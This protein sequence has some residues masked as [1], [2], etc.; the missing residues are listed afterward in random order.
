MKSLTD[1]DPV[2]S[3]SLISLIRLK[4]VTFFANLINPTWDQWNVAWWSTMEVNI[5]I[6]CTCLPTM[7]LI[8]KRIFPK[9]LA[10][11]ERTTL[12]SWT[13][14][15]SVSKEDTKESGFAMEMSTTT[16]VAEAPS[17][18]RRLD[19][20]GGLKEEPTTLTRIEG[21]VHPKEMPSAFQRFEGDT[22]FSSKAG[23]KSPSKAFEGSTLLKRLPSYRR[24][25]DRGARSV[26]APNPPFAGLEA[27]AI[28][29]EQ[30]VSVSVTKKYHEEYDDNKWI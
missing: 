4:S 14:V 6:I 30:R 2:S 1:C 3:V 22:S 10:T 19:D 15:A 28:V 13:A 29:M 7:R 11:D 23:L 26:D 20:R 18:Y 8:L 9:L 24:F 21:G 27:N 17:A 25:A 5:G 12:T 16:L